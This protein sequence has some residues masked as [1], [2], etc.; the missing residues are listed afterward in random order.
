MVIMGRKGGKGHESV[1]TWWH[2][3]VPHIPVITVI[4]DK[5]WSLLYI[6]HHLLHFKTCRLYIYLS[7][8][9]YVRICSRKYMNVKIFKAINKQINKWIDLWWVFRSKSVG[10]SDKVMHI[11][12]I[13]PSLGRNARG[14]VFSLF[15]SVIKCW[16]RPDLTTAHW[17]SSGSLL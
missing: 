10:V 6:A 12:N 16:T 5:D 4:N 14:T 9:S 7:E 2:F 3:P 11:Q 1:I 13:P 15:L 8:L 17:A